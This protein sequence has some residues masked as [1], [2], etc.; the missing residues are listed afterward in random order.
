MFQVMALV[1]PALLALAVVPAS[2][3]A[4][5]TIVYNF[6]GPFAVPA[7][8]SNPN[9]G[10]VADS[11][12]NLYGTTAAGG[13]LG[14]GC[15]DPG[16]GV[17][18]KLT[19]TL[20]GFP[21]TETV[22]YYFTGCGISSCSTPGDGASPQDTLL[23][24]KFANLYGTTSQGGYGCNANTGCGAVF[25]YCQSTSGPYC[26]SVTPPAE[27]VLAV[28]SPSSSN[29]R[30]PYGQLAMDTYGNLYGTNIGGVYNPNCG[31][32][33][34][35]PGCGSVFVVCAPGVTNPTDPSPCATGL[36][37]PTYNEI[38]Q[39]GGVPDGANPFGGLVISAKGILYGTTA[40][41]GKVNASAE[42][43]ARYIE[44]SVQPGC[45]VV[46]RLAP[47]GGPIWTE[48]VLYSFL[49]YP[50]DGSYPMD[51]L[52]VDSKGDL[53]GTTDLGPL[54]GGTVFELKGTAYAEK[55]LFKFTNR[56]DGG[57][58]Y[59]GVTFDNSYKT[60]Y[61]ATYSGGGGN[62]G[63]VFELDLIGATWKE[64]AATLPVAN[65][66][67]WSFTPSSG[68]HGQCAPSSA[69]SGDGCNPYGGVIPVEVSNSAG[70][71]T[72]YLFGTTYDGGNGGNSTAFN[73]GYG[74]VYAV[75]P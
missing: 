21:Y 24:D 5:D 26:G 44:G 23:I 54:G 34:A 12:G 3:W 9:G 55:I 69:Y 48:T 8:G 59:A 10:L 50:K 52:V 4:Q 35:Y 6:Q 68:V 25:V 33:I 28:M 15:P 31:S 71:A 61:G 53:Y 58:A 17:L 22:L 63:A 11:A 51:T 36:A 37:S 74:T 14:T 72:K 39:F 7:D 38:Y 13:N 20:G 45:G 62:N 32:G 40:S 29:G 19:P 43:C 73:Q 70:T 2:L 1:L 42:P 41:G 67:L 47:S 65:S 60:L 66:A 49:G 64:P 46:F 18:Y 16:C 57:T 27:L 56:W 75:L 30:H